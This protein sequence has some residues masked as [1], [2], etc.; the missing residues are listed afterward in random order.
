MLT[1]TVQAGLWRTLEA[2]ASALVST[3]IGPRAFT[4]CERGTHEC[5]RHN[6]QMHLTDGL[7]TGGDRLASASGGARH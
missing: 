4:K 3:Q 1:P 2:A 7:R 5:V 6:L